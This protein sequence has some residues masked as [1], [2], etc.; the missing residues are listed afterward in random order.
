MQLRIFLKAQAE[1]EPGAAQ[2]RRMECKGNGP[3]CLAFIFL[4][5]AFTFLKR[6]KE[7]SCN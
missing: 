2:E 3:P 4:T 7:R 5:D 6:K 1:H